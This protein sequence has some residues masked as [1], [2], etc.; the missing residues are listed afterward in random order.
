[1]WLVAAMLLAEQCSGSALENLGQMVVQVTESS[2]YG[3]W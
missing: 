2:R 3:T 1:M